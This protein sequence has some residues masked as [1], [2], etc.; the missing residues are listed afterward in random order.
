[1]SA[2]TGDDENSELSKYAAKRLREQP[3]LPAAERPYVTSAPTVPSPTH[4]HQ[5]RVHRD[6]RTTAEFASWPEPSPEPP[7]Q[8]P[9][10]SGVALIG[11]IAV[12][13]TFA[14]AVAL[15]VI[16]AK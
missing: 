1:M 12:V 6:R 3:P 2:P 5:D 16:F 13:V 9:K 11:R 7:S 15:L 14:A 4:V 8:L 10:H